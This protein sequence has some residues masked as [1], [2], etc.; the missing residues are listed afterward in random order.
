MDNWKQIFESNAVFVA[1]YKK[2]EAVYPCNLCGDDESYF[3]CVY[4]LFVCVLCAL[5]IEYVRN[6]NISGIDNF[7]TPYTVQHIMFM[8]LKLWLRANL[9]IVKCLRSIKQLTNYF[10]PYHTKFLTSW[11]ELFVHLFEDIQENLL[12]YQMF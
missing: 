11:K 2:V 3:T 5:F 8:H 1:L 10:R 12:G 9:K 4:C 6:K 7:Y